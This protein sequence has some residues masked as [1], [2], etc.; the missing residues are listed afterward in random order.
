MDPYVVVN[1]DRN[2]KNNQYGWAC[3]TQNKKV[4]CDIIFPQ[5]NVKRKEM[6]HTLHINLNI[7]VIV[8]QSVERSHET[9][10]LMQVTCGYG[11]GKEGTV[12]IFF[13]PFFVFSYCNKH[14]LLWSMVLL[15]KEKSIYTHLCINS[16][17]LTVMSLSTHVTVHVDNSQGTWLSLMSW[18]WIKCQWRIMRL[19]YKRLTVI[20]LERQQKCWRLPSPPL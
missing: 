15:L 13:P 20:L 11:A 5:K 17:L 1:N 10:L 18:E 4:V 16:Q 19:F 3:Y 9:T 8:K 14:L 12:V 2:S 6:F 7:F